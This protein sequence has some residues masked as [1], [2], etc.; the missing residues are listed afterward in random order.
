MKLRHGVVA[1]ALIV[2]GS[3]AA[4]A[5]GDND[6]SPPDQLAI[7]RQLKLYAD[8]LD[9]PRG[10]DWPIPAAGTFD[11]SDDTTWPEGWAE[12]TE[13]FFSI[14]TD[15]A[16]IDYPHFFYRFSGKDNSTPVWDGT[17]FVGGIGYMFNA[18]NMA[19]QTNSH[20]M[21]SNIMV[22]IHGNEAT[23]KDRFSHIGYLTGSGQTW[24]DASHTMGFHEGKW[25]KED[26]VWRCYYWRGTVQFNS[27]D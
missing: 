17:A 24:P 2:F 6:G 10:D 1:I 26:G 27:T 23:S 5:G 8:S 13:Q 7:Q 21:L 14:F 25:R 9:W 15:D 19:S 16:V 18:W 20:T 4:L 3:P 12:G 22:T 11:P